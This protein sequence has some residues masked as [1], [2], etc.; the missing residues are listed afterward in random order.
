MFGIFLLLTKMYD[1]DR[2][3]KGKE[4]EMTFLTSSSFF[5]FTK[6]PY[7]SFSLSDEDTEVSGRRRSIGL[8]KSSML[9]LA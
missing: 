2:Q 3:R 5:I 4:G 9:I 1:L 7:D 6:N 8:Q